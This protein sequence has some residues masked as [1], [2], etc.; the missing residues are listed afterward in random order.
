VKNTENE[1]GDWDESDELNQEVDSRDNIYEAV[2]ICCLPVYFT[3]ACTHCTKVYML[4]L[5]A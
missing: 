3:A 4:K 2:S 1:E 5:F